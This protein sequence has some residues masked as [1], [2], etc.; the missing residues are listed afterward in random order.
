MRRALQCLPAWLIRP[1]RNDDDKE[2]YRAC[3]VGVLEKAFHVAGHGSDDAWLKR[4]V[5]E[6]GPRRGSE[7]ED[8]TS[9]DEPTR[10]KHVLCTVD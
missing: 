2:E 8:V 1:C 3:R 7:R 4:R 6:E 5:R 10:P 9:L